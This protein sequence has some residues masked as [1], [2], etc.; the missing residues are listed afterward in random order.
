MVGPAA[1]QC[2]Q[3]RGEG[4][5]KDESTEVIDFFRPALDR[6][7]QKYDDQ[8]QGGGA[9][10]HVDVEYPAPRHLIDEIAPD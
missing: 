2:I 9:D 4:N 8:Q 6:L 5:G 10:R 3:Q 7:M 1:Q